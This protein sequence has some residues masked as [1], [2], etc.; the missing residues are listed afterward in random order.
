MASF[1]IHAAIANE[2]NKDLKRNTTK[3]LLGTIAPDISKLIG[4][5]KLY[6]HFQTSEKSTPSFDKFINIYGKYLY[7]DFVLGY[8]IHLYVDYLWFKYFLP[9][10]YDENKELLT[11]LDGSIVPCH[12]QMLNN[13]IYNDYTNLNKKI[14][15]SYKINLNFLYDPIPK[16]DNIIME[17]HINKLNVLIDKS[18][19]ILENTKVNKELTFNMENIDN[20]ISLSVRLISSN[21]MELGILY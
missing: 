9:E 3:L 10:I 14:I 17:A 1:M 19:E 12:G 8:Y 20:F 4:E 16:I 7:D 11:K 13:Y 6:T 5:T 15:E 21:L 2:L 18:K